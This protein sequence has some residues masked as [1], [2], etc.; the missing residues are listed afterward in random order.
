[1]LKELN[2]AYDALKHAGSRRDYDATVNRGTERQNKGTTPREAPPSNT[3]PFPKPPPT[4]NN[5]RNSTTESKQ[6]AS[7]SRRKWPFSGAVTRLYV[8]VFAF[9]VFRP[10]LGG[11]I[12][13][14]S[15]S[16]KEHKS[17][18]TKATIV[19]SPPVFMAS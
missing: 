16:V 17:Q 6:S 14:P 7:Q 19:V 1:M 12:V 8:L 15:P 18:G 11:K 10:L 3:S 9:L 4:Q 2:V 13:G 5:N